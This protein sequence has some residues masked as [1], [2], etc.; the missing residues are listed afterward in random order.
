MILIPYTYSQVNK[1][2]RHI[3][4]I[5]VMTEGGQAFWVEDEPQ[6][7]LQVNDIY[8]KSAFSDRDMHYFEIDTTKTAMSSMYEWSELPPISDTLC[9]RTFYI[10]TDADTNAWIQMPNS[11]FKPVLETILRTVPKTP[12]H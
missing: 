11:I 12:T 9:W 2:G 3:H 8:S 6:E 7:A 10:I 5:R 1:Y 4:V